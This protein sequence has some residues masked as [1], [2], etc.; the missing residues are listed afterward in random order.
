VF[1]GG[2]CSP[3]AGQPGTDRSVVVDIFDSRTQSWRAARLSQRR[4][5]L[6]ACGVGQ[7]FAIFGGG[8]SDLPN[9]PTSS[10]SSSSSAGMMGGGGG[11][12]GG[13]RPMIG[14]SNVVDIFDSLT[15]SW[16]NA[17]LSG[18]GRCCLGAAGG[19]A[20]FGFFGGSTPSLADLFWLNNNTLTGGVT[21]PLRHAV[22]AA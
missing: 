18:D 7:R 10:S 3:C 2:F 11:G 21:A 8:S 22:A 12:G 4:S 6:A 14:R 20:T 13:H 17:T 9:P 19:N 15:G 16:S 1:A 5:N